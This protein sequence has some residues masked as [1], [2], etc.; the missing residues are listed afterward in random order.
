MKHKYNNQREKHEIEQTNE[1][2][3][4]GVGESL[5]WLPL[6]FACPS[7]PAELDVLLQAESE[8]G[9]SEDDYSPI[10]SQHPTNAVQENDN[11]DN[12]VSFWNQNP[13]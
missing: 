6:G 9:K 13:N 12:S 10:S 1:E 11:E 8:V 5:S 3:F 7:P 4:P 2:I